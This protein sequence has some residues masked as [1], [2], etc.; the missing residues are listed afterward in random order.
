MTGASASPKLAR[1]TFRASRLLDFAGVKELTAQTGHPPADWPLVVL[2]ELLDNA[3]DAC[4]EAGIAPEV[5][6]RVGAHGIGVADN[7]PGLPTKLVEDILDFS[8]RVSSREAYVSPSRGAQGNALKTLVAM[9]FALDGRAGRVEID[10]RGLRHVITFAVDPIRQQ[11]VI[12]HHQRPGLVKLGTRIT[13][14]WPKSASSLLHLAGPRFL[15]ML[16]DFAWLNPHLTLSWKWFGQRERIP[17]THSGWQ[18][19][20][21]SDP[22]SAH[23]Y[24]PKHLERLIAAYIAHDEDHR[25]ARTVREFIGEFRGFAGSAAQKRVLDATGLTREPLSALRG[26]DRL[27]PGRIAALLQAMQA[28]SRPVKAAQLGII[29]EAHLRRLFGWLDCEMETFRYRRIVSES[30]IDGLPWVLEAAFGYCPDADQ[31]VLV[32]GV[33]FSPAIGN[34]FK[35]IGWYGDGLDAIL[36]RQR[37]DADEPVVVFL[38]L[39]HP[40]A[41]FADRGKSTITPATIDATK[42]TEIIRS[43]T[44]KWEKQRKAEERHV[45]ARLRRQAAL[46]KRG[47]EHVTAKRAAHEAIPAAYLKASA[48]NKLPAKARQVM[49]AARG[50]I[51]ERT[52][53]PLNDQRFCQRLLPDFMAE[54]PDLTRDWKIVWDARG[55]MVEPHTSRSVPLGTLEV[56]QYLCSAGEPSWSDPVASVPQL[57]TIGPSH[58]YGALLFIEKEGFGELF[59]A[60]QLAERY[61]IAILSTK[62]M[63]VTACRELADEL[64]HRYGIPLFVLHDFD[65]AGFSIA[66][67]LQRDTRRYQFRNRI[68]VIDLGLRLSDVEAHGLERES[69]HF[70]DSAEAV[71][72]NLR[73]NGASEEEIEFLLTHRVELNAFASDALV[74]WIVA[75]LERHGVK[76]VIPDEA[77]LVEAYRRRRQSQFLGE[78]FGELVDRSR[79]HVEGMDVPS[80]LAERVAHLLQQRPALSW[81]DAVAELA[82]SLTGDWAG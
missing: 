64:C 60:V 82:A 67:T 9:P 55:H 18:K 11:P 53:K 16:E 12:R 31:R 62:G 2:K 25:R 50:A 72:A 1:A 34:P 22:T 71:R 4:E 21:P 7:G 61:D 28:Q 39:T 10:A 23:W 49:Y 75:K 52:G 63:S 37:A 43:V 44:G 54:H 40:R 20:R 19:W 26:G 80:G 8:V 48:N 77:V 42:I 38:H 79:R 6:V 66:A 5:A 47:E 74:E 46:A 14:R 57:S 24:E 30:D 13:V 70:E 32:T 35:R 78:H 3:L 15:Q 36:A 65:K 73:R 81:D 69:V 17:A 59:R 29:G 33:N 68:E 45:S 41:E 27:D 51:Q 56:R 76:K 58:R